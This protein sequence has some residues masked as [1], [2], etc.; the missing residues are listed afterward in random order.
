[1]ASEATARDGSSGSEQI[2]LRGIG[3]L[4]EG[5]TFGVEYGETVIIGRSSSCD[6]SLKKCEKYLL[7]PAEERDSEKHFQTVSRKHVRISFYNS[8]SIEVEDLS[9]NGTYLD[10]EQIQ[11]VTISDIKDRTHELLLGTKE[12]FVI[13]W[14]GGETVPTVGKAT[15][16]PMEPLPLD[17]DEDED[18]GK[19]EAPSDDVEEPALVRVGSREAAGDDEEDDDLD[20]DD[21]ED[22]DFDLDEDED[23]AREDS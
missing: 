6:I 1:M 2:L 4:V 9:S 17:E 10:G 5:E 20:L 22:D 19:T 3:G 12:K 7:L 16:A 23:E 13:E 15:D 21:D 18:G 8:T 11:R 14:G